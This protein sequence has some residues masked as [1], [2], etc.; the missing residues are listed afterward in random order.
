MQIYTYGIPCSLSI[1]LLSP[2]Y[3]LSHMMGVVLIVFAF[4][5]HENVHTHSVCFG[6]DG[7]HRN[8]TL[9]HKQLF[10][11]SFVELIT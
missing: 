3:E 5:F 4:P 11:I 10:F 1:H 2:K 9:D 8:D 7:T 6:N